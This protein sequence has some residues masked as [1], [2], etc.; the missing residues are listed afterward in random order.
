MNWDKFIEVYSSII[1]KSYNKLEDNSFACFVVSELR[2]YRNDGRY[3]EGYYKGFVPTTIKLFEDSGFKFYNDL[4]LQ[5]PSGAAAKVSNLYF[6]KNRKI[7]S[8]NASARCIN[9]DFSS[10][11]LRN[12]LNFS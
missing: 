8:N 12:L 1:Q 2:E 4:I 11:S 7:A 6:N 9:V 5:N 10:C 3:S